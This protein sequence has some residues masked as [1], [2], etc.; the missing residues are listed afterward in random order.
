LF[1]N[2]GDEL[3][4][5]S[6]LELAADAAADAD[7]DVVYLQALRDNIRVTS[8]CERPSAILFDSVG[9]HQAVLVRTETHR[10]F[11][12]DTRYRIKADRDVQLRMHL[13][14]CRFAAVPRV[15]TKFD[16]GGVSSTRIPRKE[17]ENV[18]ICRKNRVGYLWTCVA[19]VMA[20]ARV[21]LFGLS[22]LGGIHWDCVKGIAR[23]NFR[24]Q[25]VS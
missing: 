6:S 11:T 2:A 5:E 3:L 15:I 9:N 7:A 10:K 16:G 1:L 13:A 25:L 19:I 18:S 24:P 17:W 22:R 23:L 4:A 20:V 12:F 8:R 14:G 21:S